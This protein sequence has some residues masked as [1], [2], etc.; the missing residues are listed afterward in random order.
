[1]V[2]MGL[3]QGMGASAAE[4]KAAFNQMMGSE[5]PFSRMGSV[6]EVASIVLFLASPLASYVHGANIRV[7]GGW[8]PTVN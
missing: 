8:V 7:D 4:V 2:V 6:D 3:E 5:A 1:M